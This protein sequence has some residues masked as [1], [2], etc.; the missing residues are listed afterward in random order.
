MF[1]LSSYIYY[2]IILLLKIFIQF[3]NNNIKNII[4]F[5][6]DLK[7]SDYHLKDINSNKYAYIGG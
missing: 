3:I 4:I 7:K 1:I 6:I 2:L 5:F